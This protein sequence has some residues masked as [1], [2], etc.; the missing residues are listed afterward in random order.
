MQ[1]VHNFNAGPSAMPLAVLQKVQAE[2]LDFAGTGMSIVEISHRSERYQQL[3]EE[4]KQTLR[5][6]LHIPD[7]YHIIFFAG[8]RQFAICHAQRQFFT[9]PR[10]LCEYGRLVG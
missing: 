10:G 1:R 9:S 5:R 7:G 6:L 4:T 2:F 3:Q 8:R